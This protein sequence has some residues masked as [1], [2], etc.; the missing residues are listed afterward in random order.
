MS[1]TA[2]IGARLERLPIS[3]FHRYVIWVLAFAFFFELGDINTLSYTAP[4]IEK[5]WNLQLSAIGNVTSATFLGM[6]LGASVIGY[7]SDRIGRKRSLIF[8]IL[9]YSIFSLLNAFAMSMTMLF[10]TRLVTG[11]GLSAM[12]VVGIT[13]I[14]E[15]F[16]AKKRGTYQ[17]LI[18]TIGLCGIPI[19]AYVARFLVPVAP[20]GWR[21]VYIWGAL[22]FIF[23][24]LAGRMYES[25]RWYENRGRL[26]DA[27][28]VMTAIERQVE[29]EKGPLPNPVERVEPAVSQRGYGELFS[30]KYLGR[31]LV[32]LVV[33]ILQTLGFYGFMSWVPTLLVAHGFSLVHSLAWS[34]AMSI[35]AVPG[36][37]IAYLLSDRL[38]RKWLVV[39]FAIAI[40]IC[41]LLY[42]LTFKTAIIIVFGFLVAMF[43]QTF[44]P[45]L[46]AYTPELYPTEVRNSGAGLVYGVGRLANVFGPMIVVAIYNHY[47]YQSVFIY[48]AAAWILLAII[49]AWFGP[50]TKG[51]MLEILNSAEASEVGNQM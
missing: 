19:T 16:P 50:R 41:G 48:I 44:A 5:A 21:F 25:P 33:W 15:V 11:F 30:G 38:D 29:I 4:A 10:V 40:S 27:N 24:I 6:F 49:T 9:I 23:A 39:I 20:W 1:S 46:Y 3:S 37:F 35:G 51:R 45:L 36:A 47:G 7:V 2:S 13:Y 22:G 34:S 43:L 26:A 18:M 14:S 31:T 42:G 8:T 28:S 17:G 32:L 12:T